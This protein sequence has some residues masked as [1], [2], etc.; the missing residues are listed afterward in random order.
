MGWWCWER[1][2][3]EA[4]RG[5]APADWWMELD[6]PRPAVCAGALREFTLRDEFALE[7]HLLEEQQGTKQGGPR[8]RKPV[9]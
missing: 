6:F 7:I 1:S 5:A 3:T 9:L 8:L 2:S 4:G